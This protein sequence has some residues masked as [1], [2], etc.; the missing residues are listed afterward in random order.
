[1]CVRVQ[2]APL[3]WRYTSVSTA[4]N[5]DDVVLENPYS[6]RAF[7]AKGSLLWSAYSSLESRSVCVSV[8]VKLP[9]ELASDCHHFSLES[10]VLLRMQ[11]LTIK[12]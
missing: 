7:K 8:T 12:Q 9:R 2:I 5:L 1:M 6:D 10:H 4:I 3:K 11:R